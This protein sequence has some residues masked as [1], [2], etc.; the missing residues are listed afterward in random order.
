MLASYRCG[1]RSVAN[2]W[3]TLGQ[4]SVNRRRGVHVPGYVV[5]VPSNHPYLDHQGPLAIAH[6]GGAG[7][8]PENTERAFR[9]AVELGFTHVETDV[10][11]TADGVAI[12]FHDDVLDRVTDRVGTIAA[13]PWSE[14]RRA[15]VDGTDEI[16]RLDQLLDGF[17]NTRFNLDPKHDAAV[18]SLAEVLR[19][20]NAKSRVCVG[21]FSDKRLDR[22]RALMGD[23]L[24]TGTGPRRTLLLLLNS[25]RI[26][27]RPRH[28]MVAQVPVKSNGI[29]IVNRRFVR[30][31]HRLGMHVHVWTIDEPAEIER[32][33]DLGVDGIMT[34][35][36][37][38][39]KSTYERRGVWN[40]A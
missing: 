17:P 24:C 16:C 5:Q 13:L 10:H 25:L 30:A 39:L 15:M 34:D 8:H 14:V 32:L 20:T 4:R 26:P 23:G 1:R 9:H 37:E 18:E 7:D 12:A 6:R 2:E 27:V 36:P 29:T 35:L 40:P 38:V 33:L 31:A 19:R 28:A 21:S 11:V 3:P 22:M